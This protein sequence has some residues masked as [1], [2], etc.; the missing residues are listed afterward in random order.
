M[1]F[2]LQQAYIA[3]LAHVYC[4]ERLHYYAATFITNVARFSSFSCPEW[5]LRMQLRAQ[6]VHRRRSK[7]LLGACIHE[8]LNSTVCHLQINAVSTTAIC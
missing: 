8:A 7:I 1:L 5:R 3:A 4:L 2:Y 6:L